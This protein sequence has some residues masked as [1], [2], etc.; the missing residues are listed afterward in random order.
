MM[1]RPRLISVMVAAVV[2][3]ASSSAPGQGFKAPYGGYDHAYEAADGWLP[4]AAP[5]AAWT[6]L[7]YTDA[8][9]AL[10]DDALTGERALRLDHSALAGPGRYAAYDLLS[11]GGAGGS[12]DFFTLDLRFRLTGEVEEDQLSLAV[13]RPP[14]EAQAA[15][16]HTEQR[17]VFRFHTAGIRTLSPGG[18][19]N[20]AAALDH[21]WHDARIT[22]DAPHAAARLYLDGATTPLLSYGG[23]G[24]SLGRNLL[25]FGDGSSTVRGGANVASLRWT[26]RSM[27]VPLE[28]GQV[29]VLSRR[30][31]AQSDEHIN[32]PFAKRFDDGTIWMTHSIGTHTVTERGARLWSLDNGATWTEPGIASISPMNSHQLDDGRV[33]ALTAWDRTFSRTHDVV[34]HT[35]AGPR[36]E[37][38]TRTV[39]VELPWSAQLFLHRTMIEA[40]DGSL[41]QTA[42]T[43]MEDQHRFRAFTLRSTDGG[44][45][46]AYHS[47]LGFDPASAFDTGLSEPAMV[48]LTDDTLLALMRTGGPTDVGPLM[49]VKSTDDGLTWSDPVQI[50]E[51]GVN[52]HVIQLASGA[53][54]ASSGRPGV[55]LLIDLTGTGEHWQQVPIYDGSTSSYTTLLE[56]EPN[57]VM[58][59][60]DESGFM[61]TD[62]PDGRPNRLYAT[63]LR[64][65]PVPEPAVTALFMFGGTLLPCGRLVERSLR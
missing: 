43:R 15:Q 1:P 44:Q 37:K 28:G 53:L 23:A 33:V 25:R 32:F 13:I 38:T 17:Y 56:I 57:L 24:G 27:A 35:W 36:S 55:Y 58:L 39:Q 3:A 51:Y 65:T 22:I 18:L 49:Q 12:N 31:L 4:D 64:V 41:I 26:N 62:L 20:A 46:W 48:R 14:T 60:H 54:V 63:Y 8:A 29:E 11:H 34:I 50:A 45:S 21:G 47:T 19:G 30:V 61:G 5:G 52:P 10:V 42:Y 7:G 40:G 6:D 16:G 9:A 2:G 59:L